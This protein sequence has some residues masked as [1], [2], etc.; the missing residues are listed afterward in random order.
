M[1]KFLLRLSIVLL[2]IFLQLSFLNLA[3]RADYVA[4]LSILLVIA[5]IVTSGFEK[6]FKW[7]IF[8]GFLN[9]IF[10]ADKIGPNI[11][12]FSFFAY[13]VSFISKRF[14]IERRFSGFLLVAVFIVIGSYLGNIFD[15]MFEGS[16]SL[17]NIS[18]SMGHY[19]AS[20]QRV[21]YGNILAGIYFY[22]I[23]FFVNGVEKYIS[24]FEDRLK[25]TL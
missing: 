8:L 25:I 20:W 19:F 14:I 10:F 3:L 9:D 16:F 24:R 15:I 23:Y 1:K 7:I 22:F 13:L 21:I 18:F 17:E 12:F 5:W 11:L 2:I 4:N 6:T